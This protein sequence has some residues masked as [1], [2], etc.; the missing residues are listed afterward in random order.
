MGAIVSIARKLC[1]IFRTK[2]R[3]DEWEEEPLE[4]QLRSRSYAWSFSGRE[5]SKST[6]SIVNKIM[7]VQAKPNIFTLGVYESLM[8]ESA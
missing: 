4:S 6:I 2:C 3:M 1:L 8:R 7:R 5:V